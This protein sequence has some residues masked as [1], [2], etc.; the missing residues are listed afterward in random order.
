MKEL[1]F[2]TIVMNV[3]VKNRF[4]A[5]QDAKGLLSSLGLKAR[6]STILLTVC[7]YHVMYAFQ[8]ESTL[9]S[10]HSIVARNRREIWSLS[11]CNGTRTHFSNIYKTFQIM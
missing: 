5:D 11:D 10:S 6:Q 4:I 8:S 3:M 7:S 9:Y 2:L 1:Y